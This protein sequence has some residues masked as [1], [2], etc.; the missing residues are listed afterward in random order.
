MDVRTTAQNTTRPINPIELNTFI[1][2]VR[3]APALIWLLRKPVAVVTANHVRTV[4]YRQQ[5]AF[6]QSEGTIP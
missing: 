4:G 2:R 6:I 1:L 3:N 5:P